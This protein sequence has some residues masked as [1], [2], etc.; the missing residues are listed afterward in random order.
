MGLIRWQSHFPWQFFSFYILWFLD[1]FIHVFLIVYHSSSI[2]SP[3]ITHYDCNLQTDW[4]FANFI[5][6]L[7]SWLGDK[8]DT[9]NLVQSSWES[10]IPSHYGPWWG[11]YEY[12]P[13]PACEHAVPSSRAELLIRTIAETNMALWAFLQ[14]RS[15]MTKAIR[16]AACGDEHFREN[17]SLHWR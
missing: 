4:N 12:K 1:F 10:E 14:A 9:I 13:S 16:Q 3:R 2:H 5:K 11:R 8:Q 15:T 17:C 6:A 7:Q